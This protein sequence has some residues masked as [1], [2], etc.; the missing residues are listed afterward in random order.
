[1]YMNWMLLHSLHLASGNRCIG[2]HQEMKLLGQ[3]CAFIPSHGQRQER[4]RREFGWKGAC[5]FS[6]VRAA[7]NEHENTYSTSKT[8]DYSIGHSPD[9]L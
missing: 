3:G 6:H 9:L 7:E 4:R 8:N 2:P 5:S 1:M